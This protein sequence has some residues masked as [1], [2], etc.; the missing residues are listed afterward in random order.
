MKASLLI[1]DVPS[2]MRFTP[3]VVINGVAQLLFLISLATTACSPRAPGNVPQILLFNGTGTSPNDVEA[4]ETIL[5][6]R[7]L[8]YATVN[9]R[10]LNHMSESQLSAYR[11][12]I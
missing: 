12:I 2:R 8:D 6:D 4:V 11:L 3:T 5:R 9:S 1:H 10:Q 7:H